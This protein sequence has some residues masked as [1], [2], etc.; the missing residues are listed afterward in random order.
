[1]ES[2]GVRLGSGEGEI[3]SAILEVINAHRPP[4]PHATSSATCE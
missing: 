4:Y 3:G 2:R 1:L